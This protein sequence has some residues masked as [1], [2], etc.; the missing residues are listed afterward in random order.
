MLPV[1]RPCRLVC[2]VLAAAMFL[3]S[4]A[5]R[6]ASDWQAVAIPTDA[7]FT[8]LWFSDSLHGWITGGSYAIPGGIAGCTRDGGKTWRFQSG[9]VP[10]AVERAG[11]HRV[12][13]RDSLRGWAA[14]D[15]G[16]LR[17]EDGGGTWHPAADGGGGPRLFD[18]QFLDAQSGWALGNGRIL[19]TDDGGQTWR[20]LVRSASENG[21][22]TG[23]AIYFVDRMHGWLAGRDGV[24]M[25][26]ADGGLTWTPVDLPLR[27]GE[28]PTLW[29]LT[30]SGPLHGWAAGERGSLFHTEDGGETWTLQENGIPV[31]RVLPKG[32]RPRHDVLP[33][34]ETE[35]DRLTISALHFIDAQ[36]GCAVGYYADVAE[37]V[38]LRTED[39]GAQWQVEHVQPGEIL[40]A[41]FVLDAAHAWAVGDRARTQSQVLLRYAPAVR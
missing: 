3:V 25:R 31:V 36:H 11:L 22:L 8:G 37:S 20:I 1:A 40:R 10:G 23:N 2:G 38:I 4:C 5:R 7:E 30:F 26:S 18:V 35:P 15:A 17:T 21:Y 13:F 41:V 28:H 9:M 39:G 32:E 16:L 19:H 34:L 29:D 12:Q 14:S 24:L 33:E 27:E 6:P